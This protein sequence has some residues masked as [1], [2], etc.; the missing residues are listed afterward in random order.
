MTQ[1]TVLLLQVFFLLVLHANAQD[2]MIM[3]NGSELQVKVLEIQP[4]IIKYKKWDNLDGPSYSE[5]KANV[6]MIKYKNGSKDVFNQVTNAANNPP[7]SNDDEKKKNALEIL[8]NYY[9]NLFG[10]DKYHI[11]NLISFEKTNG[12]MRDINGQSVYEI[13]F[14]MTIQT[15]RPGYKVGNG[16]VGYWQDFNLYSTKPDLTANGQ[17]FVYNTK[18]IQ[19]G[20]IFTFSGVGTL[21]STDNGFIFKNT[22]T[23]SVKDFGVKA[24]SNTTVEKDNN[25]VALFDN[26]PPVNLSIITG[27]IISEDKSYAMRVQKIEVTNSTTSV[28]YVQSKM[29][30]FLGKIKILE[31]VTANIA[32]SLQLIAKVRFS[33]RDY[34][35]NNKLSFFT[36]G[37]FELSMQNSRTKQI[38]F[39]NN[40]KL[41][42]FSLLASSYLSKQESESEFIDKQLLPTLGQYIVGNFPITGNIS[43]IIEKNHK[44][45]EAK[46]V[47]INVGS[48]QGVLNGFE[49]YF[50]DLGS[51]KNSDLVVKE[52]YPDYSICK[53]KNNGQKIIAANF[54]GQNLKVKTVYHPTD[55]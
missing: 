55:K 38:V 48:N 25:S 9:K 29:I 53:V 41:S 3:K 19:A 15:Q 44:N 51:G 43:E 36:D 1:K 12:V 30:N 39:I 5:N 27:H 34:S 8:A 52:I 17:M 11:Y 16:A 37:I 45:E 22:K 23:I 40:Y 54:P 6:F 33:S 31:R 18:Y 7:A 26:I 21:E 42:N 32:D 10:N 46:L 24:L 13:Y 14:D 49:F 47:K 35:T 28:S 2:Q 4:D 20:N 50:P